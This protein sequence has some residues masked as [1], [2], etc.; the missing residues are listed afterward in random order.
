MSKGIVPTLRYA[1]APA[2]IDWLCAAFGFTKRAVYEDEDGV[3]HA[4]LVRGEAM[5]MLGSVRNDASGRLQK[6]P[7]A[8]GGVTQSPY[9]VVTDVDALFARVA[10]RARRS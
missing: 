4:E 3:A 6:T 8:A 2:M 7:A 1:D 10:E 9:V 5:I